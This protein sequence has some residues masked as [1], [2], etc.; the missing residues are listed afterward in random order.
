M[1]SNFTVEQFEEELQQFAHKQPKFTR[2]STDDLTIVFY[3]DESG[4]IRR[5]RVELH[6]RTGKI[7]RWGSEREY[8]SFSIVPKAYLDSNHVTKICDFYETSE[9]KIR[10]FLDD[11]MKSKTPIPRFSLR[12]SR[13]I[14]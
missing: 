2:V 10:K 1:R 5:I 7:T 12:S 6:R 11:L 14:H 13:E 9:P 3:Y 8:I 4:K